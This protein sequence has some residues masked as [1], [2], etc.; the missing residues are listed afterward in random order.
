ME[1]SA[2]GLLSGGGSSGG[3]APQPQRDGVGAYVLAHVRYKQLYFLGMA[4]ALVGLERVQSAPENLGYGLRN[5]H[6]A[7]EL[8][9]KAAVAARKFV[10]AARSV[11][12]VD[13]LTILHGLNDCHAACDDAIARA[14]KENDAVY[15]RPL[16]DLPDA[17][18]DRMSNLSAEL[19]AAVEQSSQWTA[20]ATQALDPSRAPQLH[21][22]RVPEVVDCC[23]T[24]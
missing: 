14:K 21:L 4:Y 9:D 11:V 17:L 8:F 22:G 23:P 3:G 6:T 18:P 19:F 2:R 15:F 16:P 1:T 20:A 7:K 24:S 13:N 5:L 10:D 12:F